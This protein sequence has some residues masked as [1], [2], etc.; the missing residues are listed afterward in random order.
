[1]D[2][3]LQPPNIAACERIARESQSPEI[4]SI[5]GAIIE[6]NGWRLAHSGDIGKLL[7]WCFD[8]EQQLK[9][10]QAKSNF[11]E[12]HREAEPPVSQTT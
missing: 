8:L 2:S 1:M 3:Q 10:L 11:A 6:L 4:A 9:K 5:A 12:G 7:K